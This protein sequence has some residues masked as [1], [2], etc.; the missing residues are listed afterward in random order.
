[1]G[2]DSRWPR[3]IRKIFLGEEALRLGRSKPIEL[4]QHFVPR[5][6]ECDG[7]V[8][9][10]PIGGQTLQ[11]TRGLAGGTLASP[12]YTKEPI[13]LLV[14]ARRPEPRFSPLGRGRRSPLVELI[15]LRRPVA[16]QL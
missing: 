16:D 13:P 7:D 8:L 14:T 15:A 11:T 10:Y 12:S 1:M 2:V 6:I 4:A 9:C 5:E 3:W